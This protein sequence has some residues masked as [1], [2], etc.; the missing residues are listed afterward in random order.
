MFLISTF[1]HHLKITWYIYFHLKL[2][3]NYM[4]N[5]VPF[6]KVPENFYLNTKASSS[7]VFPINPNWAGLEAGP[8][9]MTMGHAM[10][11]ICYI[12][13]PYIYINFQPNQFVID[14]YFI[15]DNILLCLPTCYTLC[16]MAVIPHKS[17]GET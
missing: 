9:L 16:T 8:I 2:F 4:L 1:E 10:L 17:L 5:H 7:E 12:S 13:P 3:N 14:N 15:P 6:P 11:Y